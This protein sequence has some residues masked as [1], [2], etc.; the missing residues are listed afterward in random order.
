[1]PEGDLDAGERIARGVQRLVI[2]CPLWWDNRHA[3]GF[4]PLLLDFT[5]PR[6]DLLAALYGSREAGLERLEIAPEDA[7]DYGF[8]ARGEADNAEL[9]R[10][11]A[12]WV[13]SSRTEAISPN[14]PR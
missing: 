14:P 13:Y 1:M 2:R 3:P 6:H 8:A 4:D 5:D 10:L 7:A 9:R 12:V 11:W